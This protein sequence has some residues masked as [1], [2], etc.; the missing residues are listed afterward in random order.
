MYEN[1]PRF[2]HFA[3]LFVFPTV[4]EIF[5]QDYLYRIAS[6]LVIPKVLEIFYQDIYRKA[7]VLYKNCPPAHLPNWSHFTVVEIRWFLFVER[8]ADASAERL[9]TVSRLH[10][11]RQ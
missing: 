5:Y 1:C 3:S 11:L 10:G 8:L 2:I 4:L 6:L 9:S 7:I